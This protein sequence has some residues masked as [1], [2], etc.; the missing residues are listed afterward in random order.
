MV[1]VIIIIRFCENNVR[2]NV[3]QYILIS[4]VGG[5]GVHGSPDIVCVLFIKTNLQEHDLY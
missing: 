1:P 2:N 5:N 3:Y 4:C